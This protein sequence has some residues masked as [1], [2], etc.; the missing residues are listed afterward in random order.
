MVSA[1]W[2]PPCTTTRRLIERWKEVKAD[3]YAGISDDLEWSNSRKDL[4][5][6]LN[7]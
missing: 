7:E 3:G 5:V 6:F 2:S 4:F 1:E